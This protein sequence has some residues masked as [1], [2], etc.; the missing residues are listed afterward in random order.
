VLVELRVRQLGVIDDLSVEFGPGMTVLTGETGAGKTLLVEALQLVLGQRADPGL[1]RTGAAEATVEACFAEAGTETILARS[2]ARHGRSRCWVDG[3]LATLGT[4]LER[5]RTL[6]DL[7]GQGDHQDLLHTAAQRRAL[8]QFGGVDTA[9][10]EHCR[11]RV[12]TLRRRLAELG[13]DAAGRARELDVL[14]YQLGELD[15]AGLDDPDEDRWLQA[16]AARLSDLA[17]HRE[18]AAAALAAL[19]GGEEGVGAVD[20]LGRAAGALEGREPFVAL[21]ERLRAAQAEAADLGRELRSAVD[22]WED[23]PAALEA[24]LARRRQLADLYRKYGGDRRGALEFARAARERRD[25]LER[26]AEEAVRLEAELS[27]AEHDL[28]E[29]ERAVL[30]ARRQAAAQLAAA[31]EHRLAE[32]AMA[33]ARLQIEVAHAGAGDDVRF[34]FAANPGEALRPLARAASGG[35]LARTMLAL[36]LVAP[37]GPPT[38]VF[39]EVDA[40]VGGEAAL[41]L[42]RALKQVSL[43]RQVLVVTHLAQVAAFATSHLSVRKIEAG[44]R[45]STTATVVTG[46]ERVVEL[47]RML[48]GHPGSRRARAHAEELLDLAARDPLHVAR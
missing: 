9:A 17:A 27:R 13:G 26:A 2:V 45:V 40:G 21:T 38:M 25:R 31:V 10:L 7:H 20:L 28:G 46:E 37:G 15:Q 48:S 43:G 24:V 39:D 19:D 47:S 5:A 3:R 14:A 42:A 23:D 16:E 12:A 35:E 34:L 44:G 36:R 22:T 1:V 32:L 18:R 6:A 41:A 29:I 11:A 33:G 8:D 4:L 30:A